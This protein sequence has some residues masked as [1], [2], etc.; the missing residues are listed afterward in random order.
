MPRWP[1]LSGRWNA[2]S[3]PPRVER[4][5]PAPWAI[6]V[7]ELLA[8]GG[9]TLVQAPLH[10]HGAHL[11]GRR[12]PPVAPALQH[13]P[14][15]HLLAARVEALQEPLHPI[16]GVVEVFPDIVGRRGQLIEQ[17]RIQRSRTAELLVSPQQPP[18]LHG[19]AYSA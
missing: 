15:Q 9:Q 18:L 11:K 3:P 10:G 14:A 4:L 16:E 1:P 5:G 13:H 7:A 19:E 2:T 17:L 8:E 12:G 6:R